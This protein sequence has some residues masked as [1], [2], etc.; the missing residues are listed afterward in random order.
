M[1]HRVLIDAIIA[2]QLI[3]GLSIKNDPLSGHAVLLLPYPLQ[4]NAD[5][6]IQFLEQWTLQF[7]IID[8]LVSLAVQVVV[9]LPRSDRQLSLRPQI[10]DLV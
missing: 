9:L 2:E 1:R 7:D 6:L 3:P 4:G 8:C 10:H 5:L